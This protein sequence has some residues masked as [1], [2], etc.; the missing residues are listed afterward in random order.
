MTDGLNAKLLDEI[1]DPYSNGRVHMPFYPVP[2]LGKQR[3]GRVSS[4]LDR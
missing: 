1:G 2:A 3:N 4:R